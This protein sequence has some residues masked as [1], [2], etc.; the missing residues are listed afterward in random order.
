MCV[1]PSK[2]RDMILILLC[3]CVMLLSIGQTSNHMVWNPDGQMR[4]WALIF[5][6]LIVRMLAN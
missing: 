6:L 2:C 4:V 1:L 5:E 3:V